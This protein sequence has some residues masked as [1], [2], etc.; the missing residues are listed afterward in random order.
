MRMYD[1]I[2]AKRDGK[3]LSAQQIE[4]FIRAYT[5]NEIPEEQAAA[6]LMA[7]FFQGMDE[8]ETT[9]LTLAM[10]HSG[11]M[12]TFPKA[13]WKRTCDKHSTGGVG[14]KTTLIVAPM[15]AAC[16]GMVA[17]M[18]G[19]GLGHTGGTVDKLS[20]IP[21]FQTVMDMQTFLRTAQQ[22]GLCVV[23]QSG[24]LAPADKKL[25]ALRDRTA[26]VE[27]LPLIASS[28]MSKK[29][30]AGAHNIVLDVKVGSGAFMK[31]KEQGLA[32]AEQ[33]VRIGKNAGRNVTAVLT[34]MDVPLGYSIGNALEVQ[35]AVRVLRGEKVV[36]L[37]ALCITL[38]AVLCE[39]MDGM[40]ETQAI[41][42]ATQA[43]DGGEAWEAFCRMVQAQ[44]GDMH[45]IEQ[46][47][48]HDNA[49]AY[50]REV[51]AAQSGY[52]AHMDAQKIGLCAMR[53]GAGREKKD[54]I[55][56]LNAGI[57]LCKKT[58]DTVQT[59]DVIATLFTEDESRL[60][61]AEK[62]FLD[63]LTY[64]ETPVPARALVLG[65]VRACDIK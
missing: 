58:G 2:E 10:A 36:D 57:Q 12:V 35:E 28:I 62:T 26:T 16:G 50:R 31:T 55:I 25:Y 44:G 41:K 43:L 13:E 59:G 38:T 45:Y 9:A 60:N 56:D 40:D 23:G 1:L 30:A 14:D 5:N 3:R 11:D 15:V 39:M 32:L 33:M 4:Q 52:I 65:C 54:D 42:R 8:S 51:R 22:T 20:A 63:A 47:A 17:K 37:R 19:K 18:S 53:L 49:A 6:L 61:S 7:I 29:L 21:G 34:D 27:S 46:C 24:S 64:T 48:H